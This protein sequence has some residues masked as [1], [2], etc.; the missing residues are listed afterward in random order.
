MTR[1]VQQRARWVQDQVREWMES[2]SKVKMC[3]ARSQFNNTT[4]QYQE[5]KD[6]LHKINVNLPHILEI[7]TKERYVRVEPTVTVG[8][9]NSYLWD[10]GWMMP[11]TIDFN[12]LTMGGLLMG[13]AV[14]TTSNKFGLL[15][16]NCKAIELVMG[17]ASVVRCSKDEHTELFAALPWSWGTLGFITALEFDIIPY[18]TFI[19]LT[20][21][22][23]TSVKEGVAELKKA[24]YE[25]EFQSVEGFMFSKDEGI[26][27]K[28]SFA[29]RRDPGIKVNNIGWWFKPWFHHHARSK[30]NGFGVEHVEYIPTRDYFERHNRSFF[31]S[32][33][34]T[35]P[36]LHNPVA[37]FLT[38]WA[39]P[40]KYAIINRMFQFI[41]KHIL[42][43]LIVQV[44]A[45]CT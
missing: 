39:M 40:P 16:Y 8:Q 18:R 31:W 2:G 42:N 4:L 22:P 10:R 1:G 17:D 21:K 19:K 3:T 28:G 44:A 35:I 36:S 15:R 32:L 12:D 27:M 11:V 45:Y 7:N 43:H 30:C 9:L 38:G 29:D 20:Y 5:Y 24:C 14:E 33:D 13:G 34:T 26:I 37:R 41:P 25:E 23:V 6:R